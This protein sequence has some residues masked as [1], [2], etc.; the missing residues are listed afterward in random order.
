MQ[1]E[2][3]PSEVEAVPHEPGRRTERRVAGE[4]PRV[5]EPAAPSPRR[6]DEDEAAAHP[7]AVHAAEQSGPERQHQ[8]RH[9]SCSSRIASI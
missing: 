2:R 3:G 9:E 7:G 5:E 6:G 1:P 4:T 8:V